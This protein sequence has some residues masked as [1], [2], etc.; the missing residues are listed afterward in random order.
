M[1]YIAV[2]VEY[3]LI[4]A[5][6]KNCIMIKSPDKEY[7]I[8]LSPEDTVPLWGQP[9]P[10]KPHLSFD[11]LAETSAVSVYLLQQL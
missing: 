10:L 5:N 7:V 6:E 2:V 1:W 8:Q 11:P 4:W 9:S 3:I